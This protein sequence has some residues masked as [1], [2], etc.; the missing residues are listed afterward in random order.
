MNALLETVCS[1]RSLHAPEAEQLFGAMIRGE[2]NEHQVAATLIAMRVR[3]ER[4][5][6]LAGA[7]RA[8]QAMATPFP[9]PPGDH[10][11]SCGTGGDGARTLNLSTGAA[12]VAAA[13]GL[14]M[15]KH[16]NRSVSSRCGS[17]D[18]LEALGARV[19]LDP[20]AAAATLAASG[21]AYLH[22]PLY[23]RGIAR[24]MPVRRALGTRTAFNLLGPLLNPA[25]PAVQLLGVY[26]PALCAPLAEALALLG[27]RSALVVHGAGID[28]VALHGA[29]HAARLD[30]GRIETLVLEPGDFGLR[31]QPLSAIAGGDAASNA[32]ALRAALDGRG[33]AAHRHALAA[34]AGVLLWI[35][36]RTRGPAEGVAHALA[37]LDAGRP[38]AVLDAFVAASRQE[39]PDAR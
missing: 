38:R 4:P 8:L 12:F 18:V 21:V 27:C 35:A 34:N 20:S 28:E 19:E 15:V 13:C 30:D 32:A 39:A 25:R 17:A 9:T 24:L 7:V 6:E 1:G 37:A 22:A 11:D 2:L 31:A 3:G 26:D 5:E 33:D 10:A 16:G 29:T 14:P 23:H 36:G